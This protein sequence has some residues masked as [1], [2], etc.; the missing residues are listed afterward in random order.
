VPEQEIQLVVLVAVVLL[1]ALQQGLL[2]QQIKA[3]L[4]VMVADRQMDFLAAA[5]ALGQ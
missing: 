5:A 4:V 2:E 3:M 1:T